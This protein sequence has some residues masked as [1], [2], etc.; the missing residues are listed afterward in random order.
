MYAYFVN[1]KKESFEFGFSTSHIS[2]SYNVI[3]LDIYLND[4]NYSC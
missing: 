4:R 1:I 3:L 2:Y